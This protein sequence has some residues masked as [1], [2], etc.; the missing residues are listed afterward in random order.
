LQQ[1]GLGDHLSLLKESKSNWGQL[2]TC[3][4]RPGTRLLSE[5]NSAA[6]MPG[7]DMVVAGLVLGG[8]PEL[9]L[10]LQ[11]FCAN[12]STSRPGLAA[13]C[14]SPSCQRPQP[15]ARGRNGSTS[16]DCSAMPGPSTATLAWVS[17]PGGLPMTRCVAFLLRISHGLTHGF[18][19]SRPCGAQT[20]LRCRRAISTN[21]AGGERAQKRARS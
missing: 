19:K 4:S 14:P 2:L 5:K 1:S 10:V 18:S 9:C 17:S 11:Q 16:N 20:C 8:P 13:G 21:F 3:W 6:N 7:G 15:G 12:T